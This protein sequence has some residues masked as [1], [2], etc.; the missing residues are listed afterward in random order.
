MNIR[1]QLYNNLD[2]LE[3]KLDKEIDSLLHK[4]LFKYFYNNL[5]ANKIILDEVCEELGVF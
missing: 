2:K 4:D 3:T 1:R 5:W